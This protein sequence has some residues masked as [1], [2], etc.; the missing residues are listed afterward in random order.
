MGMTVESQL[1]KTPKIL[2]LMGLGKEQID[3]VLAAQK[4]PVKNPDKLFAADLAVKLGKASPDSKNI[5]LITQAGKIAAAADA[6]YWALKADKG[7]S[8]V[9]KPYYSSKAPHPTAIDAQQA[10]ANLAANMVKE[11]AADRALISCLGAKAE[12]MVA[13]TAEIRKSPNLS[14]AQIHRLDEAL[15]TFT[16]HMNRLH[17]E[18]AQKNHLDAYATE[19][20]KQV[21]EGCA[22]SAKQ[23]EKS[24]APEIGSP[25]G[26][27][28][29]NPASGRHY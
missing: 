14:P 19:V 1:G 12:D 25:Q 20:K 28:A 26:G 24:N 7:L 21:A 27:K 22:T 2:D 4:D 10:T 29:P 6:D 9:P 13:L 11:M 18:Q 15:E 23:I 5:A 8:G 17:P 16:Y 3:A